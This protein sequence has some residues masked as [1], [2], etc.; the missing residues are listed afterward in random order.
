MLSLQL[1]GGFAIDGDDGALSGRAAQKKRLALLCLMA[2]APAGAITRDKLIAWL[3]SESGT[4]RARHLLSSSVYELR[5]ALGEATIISAGDVLRLNPAVLTS[6]VAAFREAIAGADWERAAAVY[7]GPFLDGFFVADAPEFERW[8]AAERDQHA[9]AFAGA[10]EQLARTRE[11][12]ADRPGAL[13]AWR[14][15]A[16]HDPYS[17]RIALA[18]MQA[19]DAAGDRAGALQHAR[20]HALLLREDCGVEPGPEL[21]ALTERLRQAMPVAAAPPVGP[22]APVASAA[23]AGVLPLPDA[24]PQP[25]HA[26]QLASSAEHPVAAGGKAASPGRPGPGNDG[27]ERLP[28]RM[29]PAAPMFILLCLAAALAWAAASLRTGGEETDEP[30]SIAVLPFVDMTP[31]SDAEYFSDGLAEELI[32][33]LSQ[34]EGLRVVARTSAFAFKGKTTDVREIGAIL[35][36]G[37]VLEGSI[38][39]ADGRV[40]IAVQLIDTRSGY[41]TWSS[42]YERPAS[43]IFAVQE[44]IAR[45]VVTALRP[46]LLGEMPGP[47][48]THSTTSPEAYQLYM[49]GRFFWNQR[50]E[51]SLRRAIDRFEQAI[52]IDPNY[53]VAYAG[54]SDAHNTLADNGFVPSGPALERAEAAVLMALALDDRLAEAYS[55]RGHLRLHRWDWVGAEQDFRRSIE[56]D[57]SYPITHQYYA[58]LL[59]FQ[60]RFDEALTRI[61]LAQQLDPL[62]VPIQNNVGEILAFA[63]RYPAAVEQ[64]RSVLQMDSTWQYTRWVL[65]TTLSEM[66]EHQAGITELR[67]VIADNGGWHRAAVAL[68]GCAYQRAGR[69]TEAE[70]VL[71]ELQRAR[72]DGRPV[73]PYQHA[74]LLAAVGRHDEAFEMLDEAFEITPSLLGSV[75]ISAGMDPLRSDP[76]YPALLARIGLAAPGRTPR[77]ATPRAGASGTSKP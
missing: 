31:G 18:L 24:A 41:Q 7:A 17:S 68:L 21:A 45:S 46:S 27:A 61:R 13:Q 55:S 25:A 39:Q 12:Q 67:R 19:L 64:L 10:L 69:T 74:M 15:L 9:R 2:A 58:F 36:V 73:S 29:A 72:S 71:L 8:V 52:R 37:S 65:G 3:W 40:R 59:T 26:G 42:T 43:D 63:R 1:F 38:R 51:E 75:G 48:V 53:A 6:D 54:L 47:L 4:D 66:G 70:A 11:R 20:I 23:D 49:Q 34:V 57:P 5:R 30:V 50:T 28:R 22:V 33:A 60:G 76:R 62:S 77:N 32:H 14:R 56:L 44:E 35:G 16:A